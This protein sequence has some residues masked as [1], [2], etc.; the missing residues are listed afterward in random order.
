M[1]SGTRTYP[2][3]REFDE[4]NLQE[5]YVFLQVARRG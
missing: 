5:E 1:D 3:V 2:D 4:V